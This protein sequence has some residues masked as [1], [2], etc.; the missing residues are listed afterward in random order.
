MNVI[1]EK[2]LDKE[3]EME[4]DREGVKYAIRAGYDP[5]AMMDYLNRLL[6]RKK[7]LNTKVL[8]STHPKIEDRQNLI[9]KQ[10]VALNASE[11]IGANGR[12]RFERYV[13]KLQESKSGNK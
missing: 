1:L 6:E 4:A 13:S 11:I 3:L 5:N 9:K 10:L 8:E 12:K 2:G 7:E